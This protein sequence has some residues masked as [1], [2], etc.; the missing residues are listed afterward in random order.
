[1]FAPFA[2]AVP[3]PEAQVRQTFTWQAP[4]EA[5]RRMLRGLLIDSDEVSM[6]FSFRMHETVGRYWIENISAC[7]CR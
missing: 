4:S 3:L 6:H 2:A 5:R 1:M 7:P